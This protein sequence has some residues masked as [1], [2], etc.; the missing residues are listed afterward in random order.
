MKSPIKWHGGK[1]YLAKHIV[2]LMPPHVTFVEPYFGAGSV[3]FARDPKKNWAATNGES[4]PAHLRGCNEIVNDIHGHLVNFWRVLAKEESFSKFCRVIEATPC[5]E[6]IFDSANSRLARPTEGSESTPSVDDAVAF[7]ICCRQ[8]RAAKFE[9]FTT[10][11]RS[12]T[13]RGVNELP[14]AWWAAIEGLPK[15]HERLRGVVILNRDASEVIRTQDGPGTLFYIDPPYLHETRVAKSV[16]VHE[17]NEDQHRELLT[18]LLEIQG[19]VLLS[20]YPSELYDEF[21]RKGNWNR[22]DFAIANHASGSK[23]KRMITE[24]RFDFALPCTPLAIVGLAA[25]DR[26]ASLH[27]R[28]TDTCDY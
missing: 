16:Y 22:K 5:C 27:F 19:K 6:A 3:L 14:S 24:W 23:I 2:N 20:G 21:A 1:S 25:T 10:I 13:R 26:A 17:M 8:S 28:H 11:A 7:F 9:E 4:L 12:R 18:S 15:V